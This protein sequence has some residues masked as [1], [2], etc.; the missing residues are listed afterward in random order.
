MWSQRHSDVA[1][2]IGLL[3]SLPSAV[4]RRRVLQRNK[5][6][7]RNRSGTTIPSSC[8]QEEGTSAYFSVR[9]IGETNTTGQHLPFLLLEFLVSQCICNA[10]I[11]CINFVIVKIIFKFYFKDPLMKE[12]YLQYKTMSN[13]QGYHLQGTHI[14][15]NIMYQCLAI[16]TTI[17]ILKTSRLGTG[18]N[19]RQL[20]TFKAKENM[21][22]TLPVSILRIF[23]QIKFY[24]YKVTM[25][26]NYTSSYSCQKFISLPG[27]YCRE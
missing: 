24:L 18:P 27:Y 14:L 5:K 16:M 1:I 19:Q 20:L 8:S 17:N 10:T 6:P 11:I 26:I 4:P 7:P 25:N 9:F 2:K 23:Y 12:I 15:L 13:D 3:S 22:I 21:L